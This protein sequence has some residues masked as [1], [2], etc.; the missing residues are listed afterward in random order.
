MTSQVFPILGEASHPEIQNLSLDQYHRATIGIACSRIRLRRET[1][2]P[3]DMVNFTALPRPV[4]TLILFGVDAV[5][6]SAAYW[7][8]TIA[9]TDATIRPR[10]G[11]P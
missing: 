11:G 10:N 4:K 9:R 5:L 7:L 2:R 6:A 1:L 8:A 3:P